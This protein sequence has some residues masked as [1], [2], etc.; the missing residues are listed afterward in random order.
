[1]GIFNLNPLPKQVTEETPAAT[2]ITPEQQSSI[3]S[4]QAIT[5]PPETPEPGTTPQVSN[6]PAKPVE[7][8][9]SGPLGH[10][11][12]QA[13]NILLAKEDMGAMVTLQEEW[14][15]EEQD[16]NG[17]GI[18]DDGKAYVYVTDASQMTQNEVGQAYDEIVSYQQQHP[19]SRVVVGLESHRGVNQAASRFDRMVSCRGISVYYKTSSIQNAIKTLCVK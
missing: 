4:G 7:I 19:S 17:T 16:L 1:M 11:Y 13:L 18:S 14:D 3:L 8:V 10:I 12:T 2:A 15:K 9:L 5:S 6:E